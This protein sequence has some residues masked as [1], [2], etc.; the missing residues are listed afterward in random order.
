[1]GT[2]AETAIVDYHLSFTNQGKQTPIFHFALQQT[3]RSLSFP[4]TVCNK[5]TEVAI[6]C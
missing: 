4:F 1:M 5:Q 2:F 6:F 3:S